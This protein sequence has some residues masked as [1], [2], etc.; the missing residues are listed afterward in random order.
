[1]DTPFPPVASDLA[2]HLRSLIGRLHPQDRD[3]AIS[4]AWVAHLSGD[5]VIAA[6]DRFRKRE[7]AHAKGA[8]VLSEVDLDTEAVR[9]RPIP[10]ARPETPGDATRAA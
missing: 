3:D 2:E 1:M 8:G 10:V 6:V 9:G 4:E 5:D 7:V